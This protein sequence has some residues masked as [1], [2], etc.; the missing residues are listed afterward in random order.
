MSVETEP[1]FTAHNIRFEDGT[2]TFPSIG[3][4]MDQ[5]PVTRSVRRVLTALYPQGFAG[6]T[7]IDV[8]CLEGGFAT[9]F[10]RMGLDATGVE[11]RE[12][13]YRNCLYVKE[14]ANLPNLHFI[15]GD[16]I[17]ISKFGPF[18]V[19]FVSGLLYHLDRPRKF[20]EDVARNCGKA[21]IIWTHVTHAEETEACMTYGLSDLQENEGLSGRWYPEHGDIPSDKLNELKWASW[22]NND[23][24]WVQKEYLLQLLKEIGFDLVFEQFDCLDDII[25][26]MT[27]G[28]YNKIDRVMLVAVKTGLITEPSART[29]ADHRPQV[30]KP[31]LPSAKQTAS[32][33][34][35][36]AQNR[37]KVAEQA[38]TH[39]QQMVDA[40]H[41]S[42][43]WR[44]T[45]P[46]RWVS[47]LVRRR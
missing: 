22:S 13:N 47:D 35:E 34:L 15:Q 14:R 1:K 6:K 46:L 41:S 18:D 8:G 32:A 25:G 2:E 5:N 28:F 26:D 30:A 19:F 44:V 38:L 33:D 36:A 21:L 45:Q 9:E 3:Y 43:S 39:S 12:S 29:L 42:T 7:I 23:S 20:L 24:F 16:A 27:T 40:L 17:D 31:T 10:A 4:T 11:V 37:A